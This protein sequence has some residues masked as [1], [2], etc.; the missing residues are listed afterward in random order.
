MTVEAKKEY[1]WNQGW[2]NPIA[3]TDVNAVVEELKEIQ[4]VRGEINPAFVLESARNKKSV[5]H[6]YFIWDDKKAADKWRLYQAT[7]LLRRIE[8]KVVTNGETKF[9]RAFEVIKKDNFNAG[10]SS[11]L[12]DPSS[13]SSSSRAAQIATEDLNRTINRLEPFTEYK[14]VVSWLKKTATLLSSIKESTETTSE[15]KAPDLRKAV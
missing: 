8:V 7:E 10:S 11:I 5:L 9:Y 2:A 12:F 4:E 1:Q 3:H 6:A 13:S 14:V 15:I